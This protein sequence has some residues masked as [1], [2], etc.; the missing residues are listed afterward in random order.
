MEFLYIFRCAS[1]IVFLI[2]RSTFCFMRV[3]LDRWLY[4]LYIMYMCVFW[5]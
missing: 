4:I 5:N 3:I 1:G 2:G